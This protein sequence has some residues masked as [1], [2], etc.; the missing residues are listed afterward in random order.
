ML[1]AASLTQ[2]NADCGKGAGKES[3]LLTGSVSRDLTDTST[4]QYF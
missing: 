1:A 4:E 3:S 2:L